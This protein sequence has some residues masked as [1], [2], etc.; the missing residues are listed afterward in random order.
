MNVIFFLGPHKSAT[1]TLQR[2][3][4]ENIKSRG[5]K[6]IDQ[7]VI[8]KTINRDLFKNVTDANHMYHQG[9]L[10]DDSLYGKLKIEFKKILSKY[11]NFK[12][13]IFFNENFLGPMIGHN[14][15][16]NNL[17][18]QIYPSY[19]ILIHALRSLENDYDLSITSL[20]IVVI[21]RDFYKWI[22]SVANDN[23]KKLYKNNLS[24]NDESF[25]STV[26]KNSIDRFSRL[27]ELKEIT[28]I[29]FN[30]LI[31]I[32]EVKHLK[33]FL[34]FDYEFIKDLGNKITLKRDNPSNRKIDGRFKKQ[35]LEKVTK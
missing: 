23:N 30:S 8:K 6:Y 19:E 1:S 12:E 28:V 18:R 16:G 29:E 3:F 27:F 17:C 35:L 26:D 5:I 2:L 32:S 25:L 14:F 9:K 7:H 20:E 31:N 24:S 4:R 13:I 33:E 22:I 21:K 15:A 10:P 11:S 34:K